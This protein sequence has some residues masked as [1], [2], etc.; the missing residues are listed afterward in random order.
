MDIFHV[1][2]NNKSYAYPILKIVVCIVLIILFIKRDSIIHIDNKTVNI[3]IGILCTAIGLVC[4][5]CAE[6]SICELLQVKENRSEAMALS[7]SIVAGCKRY[8]VNDIVSLAESNDIIEIRIAFNNRAITI[9]TSSD[10]K[11]GSSKFFDKLYYIGNKEFEDAED[12]KSGLLKYT[13]NGEIAV[14]A[15]DG[16]STHN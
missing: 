6:I 15:I 14:I 7:D 1:N 16:I 3:V 10:C 13:V 9:G 4:I 8:T 2:K 5:Y 11:N 12:F